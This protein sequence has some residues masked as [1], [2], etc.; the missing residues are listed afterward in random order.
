MRAKKIDRNQPELVNQLRKIPGLTVAHTHTI[1]K[2]FPDLAVGFQGKTWLFEVKDPSNIPSQ[3]KLTPDEEQW[4][5]KW[6]GHVATVET[7]EDVMRI[8]NI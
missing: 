4:H 5:K 1:G 2:G 7:I 6:T 3:R 8:L